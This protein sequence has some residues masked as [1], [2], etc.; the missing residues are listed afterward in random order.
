MRGRQQVEANRS[1]T[2]D[3][4]RQHNC[5]GIEEGQ[6]QAVNHQL[7]AQSWLLPRPV[8]TACRPATQLPSGCMH[9]TCSPL[10]QTSPIAGR[11]PLCRQG[12]AA[13]EQGGEWAVEPTLLS[14]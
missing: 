3:G 2:R 12:T 6:P 13:A 11:L 7:E 8:L 9:C 14:W 10:P 1:S 4:G 5:F